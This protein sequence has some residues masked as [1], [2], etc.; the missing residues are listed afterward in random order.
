ME[1]AFII[2]K[3]ITNHLALA[4]S[5]CVGAKVSPPNTGGNDSS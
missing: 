4:L 5:Y 2:L 3:V 1:E